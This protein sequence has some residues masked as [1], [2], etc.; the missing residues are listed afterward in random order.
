[1]YTFNCHV[2]N[3]EYSLN[4]DDHEYYSI[5]ELIEMALRVSAMELKKPWIQKNGLLYCGS[6]KHKGAKIYEFKRPTQSLGKRL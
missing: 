3:D 4:L 2:C 5:D 1:M 6:C